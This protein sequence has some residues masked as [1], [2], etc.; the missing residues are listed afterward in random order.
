MM[1]LCFAGDLLA[2]AISSCSDIPSSPVSASLA[3]RN[4][5]VASM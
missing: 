2:R 3:H 5:P 1:I 4:P